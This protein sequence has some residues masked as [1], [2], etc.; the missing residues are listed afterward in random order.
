MIEQLKTQVV[1][2]TKINL[3]NKSINDTLTTEL[4]RFKE[5]VEVLKEGQNVDLKSNDNVSD[6]SAQFVEIDHLKQNL[7]EYLKEKESLMQTVSLLKND[8]KKEESRNIDREIA[9]E[10]MIKQIDNIIF[11]RDQSAQ[12]KAQQLEPKLYDGNVIK[13]TSAIVIPDSEETLMLAE[14]NPTFLVED[15]PNLSSQKNFLKSAWLIHCL[16][17]LKHHL[18]GFDVVVKER[19]TATAITEGS[20]G[21]EHTKACFGD[22]IIPFVKALKDLFNTFDQYLIDEL[23]E[24]QNVFHQME[25]A[26]EQHRL[27]SKIFEVKMNQVLNENERLLEQIINKDIVNI[28]MNSSVD[29]AFVNVHE[30]EKCLKLKTELLNKEDF[31][32]KEIYDKLFK[33][34]TTLE[35]HCISLEV[36]TQLNQEIFQ[37]DNSE[38]VL[39]I[40]A[41]KDELRKVKGK[42]LVD[43]AVTKHTIDPE[44]L[45]NDVEPITPK[46]LNNRTSHSAYIKHTQ[47]EAAVL[48]NLVEHVKANYLLD[49]RLESAC[50]SSSS[51]MSLSKAQKRLRPDIESKRLSQ[52]SELLEQFNPTYPDTVLIELTAMA[53]EH[54]SSEPPL[55]EMT[56]ATISSGLVPNPPLSTPFVPPSRSDWDLLFQ[57]LF[58]ELITSPPS[59]DHPAP[60]VITPINEV[61]SL[62][63]AVS[64]GSPSS[65]TVDKD[66]PSPSNSQTIPETQSPILPNDVEKDNHDL[67]VAH[68]NNDPFFGITILENNSKA[69]SLDVI[70]T[71]VQTVAPNSEHTPTPEQALILLLHAFLTS[72]EPKNYKDALTQACWIEAMQEE[73]HEFDRLEVWKLVPRVD[74]VMIITLKWIYKVKLDEMRGIL[75][76][77]ARLVARGYRQEER[78]DFKESFA[79]VARLDAIRIFLAFAAHMNMIVYQMDVK[80]SFLNDILREEVYVS[81]PNGFVDQDNPN[82][83]Y[84]LKKALYGLKQA[85][86][87][88]FGLLDVLSLTPFYQAFLISA[89]VPAIY[90]H[91]FWA[92]VTFQKHHI[93]FKMNKKSYS[94]DL[95]TFRNM[96]QICPEDPLFEDE[97]LAFISDI[98]YP[99]Q[100]YG[101]IL[102]DYLT[103]QAMK[104]S[105]AYKT[106]YDLATGKV[107]PKLKYVRRSSRAK[108]D[109]TPK[110]PQGIALTEAEQMNIVTKRSKTQL[111]SS[112]ASSLGTYEGTGVSPGVPD[113]PTYGSEDEQISWKSIEEDNDEDVSLSKDDDDDVDDQEYDGQDDEGPDD[114]NEQ[115]DSDNDG[116]DFVHPKFSTQD[117]EERQDEE[118]KEEEGSNLRGEE[119]DEEETNEKDE[120]NELYKDVNV[121]LEGRDAKMKDAPRTIIQPTQVIEDTLV[122]ITPVN[123]EGQQQSS[124][125]SSGFVSN[126]LNPSPDTGIDSIFN[127][128]TESTSLVDVPV[129]TIAATPLLSATT[130]PPPPIP[131]IP[132]SLKTLE[133][134]FSEFKQTNQFAVAVSSIP[135]IVDAYLTN[136]MH[137]AI[138]TVDQVKEQVKA[139]VS[140]ILPKIEKTVNEQLEAEIL[141]DKMESNKS[142][143]RSDE[144]KNLYKAL[145]DAYESDKL[146]LDTYGDTVLFKRGHDDEDKDE[147]PSS[148]SNRGSKR[149]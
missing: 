12:T 39:E 48:T 13:N 21:F 14:E 65:K 55:H 82:H 122:I 16:K 54:R 87:V 63:P 22:E 113:V 116:D 106:Y 36:D 145:V 61:V 51:Y 134:D 129:T 71:V 2:C 135:G 3:D 133:T 78:I 120:A 149:R 127:L 53:S 136:K 75:K 64:I 45:K 20:W 110:A 83:V 60:E 59:V 148:R 25:Q 126:M 30:C 44:M 94:F 98:G 37:S 35:K 52:M 85:P 112:H 132:H 50:R 69:S 4:E 105:E 77:K 137:E 23:S 79:T 93:R 146:I 24:V 56:P 67:D 17:K 38:K 18:A 103:N 89:S 91:E 6:S 104:E 100:K 140:K 141:I 130:L 80:T 99:V 102:P 84:K 92:T 27:E 34:F 1:N 124:S 96:L 11:K 31:V 15:L 138:K 7:F 121:N 108:T 72:I 90:M 125:V 29:N 74:K 88:C 97:I 111:H 114:V 70:P 109:Q 117:Q 46:L 123:P 115:T 47:E 139:Q 128:N 19:F 28:I 49:H 81:Q 101:A 144:Q 119:L 66:A 5:Q 62:V 76:N 107:L 10:K 42:A 142:I 33:S 9:L 86:R 26:V 58:D 43:N 95:E 57:P 73:L 41:L 131:L 8:I 118:D 40:T 143:H 68:M 147:E 32:E